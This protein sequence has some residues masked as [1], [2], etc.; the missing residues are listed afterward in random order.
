LIRRAKNIERHALARKT[1][2]ILPRTPYKIK[3]AQHHLPAPRLAHRVIAMTP[4][5]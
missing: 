5:F 1:P 2:E 3:N 4:L